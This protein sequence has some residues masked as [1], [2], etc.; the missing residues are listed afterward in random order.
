LDFQR[1]ECLWQSVENIKSWLD[2]FY[3]IPCSK[4]V[5][6][7]FHLWSQMILSNPLSMWDEQSNPNNV[8]DFKI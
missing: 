1:L 6:Q 4:L 3:R 7:P 5:G 8:L 2:E